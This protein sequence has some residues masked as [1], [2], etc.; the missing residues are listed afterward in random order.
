[1]NPELEIALLELAKELAKS[2]KLQNEMIERLKPFIE[3]TTE[4]GNILLTHKEE[5]LAGVVQ[6]LS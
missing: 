2:A 5:F 1:M 6:N 3:L 4:V